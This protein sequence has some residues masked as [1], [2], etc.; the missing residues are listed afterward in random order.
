[1]EIQ[2]SWQK[3][4]GEVNKALL[5]GTSANTTLPSHSEHKSVRSKLNYTKALNNQLTEL[6]FYEH[7]KGKYKTIHEPGD[8]EQEVDIYDGWAWKDTFDYNRHGRN[9]Y[10]EV[11]QFL[12][13]TRGAKR[14][15]LFDHTSRTKA[16][17]AKKLTRE[18]ETS[19]R[20]PVR[21]VPCDYT[22]ESGP[23]RVHQLLPTEAPTLLNHRTA[24]LNVWKPLS[25]VEELPLATLLQTLPALP[26]AHRRELRDEVLP[27]P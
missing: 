5:P 15:L 16:N 21:L 23:T 26:R 20:A 19:Q 10:P 8:D 25:K 4:Q 6:Y 3:T 22:A 11:I 14:V 18:N 24:F 2:P 13:G 7:D 9:F 27:K 1:M 17:A 12:K